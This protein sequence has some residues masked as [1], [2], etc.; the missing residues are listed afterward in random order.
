MEIIRI[1]APLLLP[2]GSSYSVKTI[3]KTEERPFCK[4][5]NTLLN[6]GVIVYYCRLTK[7]YFC[8]KCYDNNELICSKWSKDFTER[9]RGLNHADVLGVING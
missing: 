1:N 5:C 4:N 2:N 7:F 9:K 3:F 8:Y 6:D